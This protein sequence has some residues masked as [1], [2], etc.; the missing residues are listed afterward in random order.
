[1]IR[2]N[3]HCKLSFHQV[4]IPSGDSLIPRDRDEMPAGVS[5]EVHLYFDRYLSLCT[6]RLCIYN[7][8]NNPQI[9]ITQVTLNLGRAG[10]NGPAIM[11]LWAPK[12]RENFTQIVDDGTITNEEIQACSLSDQTVNN[13]ASLYDAII[14]GSIYVNVKGRDLNLSTNLENDLLRGQVFLDS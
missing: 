14:R 6:Y 11:V 9:K 5:G 7:I 3:F 12:K 4:V 10:T 8:E 13:I 1:M 2:N